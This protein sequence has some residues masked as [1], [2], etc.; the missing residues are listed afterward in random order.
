MATKEFEDKCLVP[1]GDIHPNSR[2][3]LNIDEGEKL[4]QSDKSTV[5]LFYGQFQAFAI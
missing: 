4:R 3:R 1:M 2:N 5:E